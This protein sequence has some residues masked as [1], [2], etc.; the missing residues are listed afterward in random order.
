MINTISIDRENTDSDKQHFGINYDGYLSF[1]RLLLSF[2]PCQGFCTYYEMWSSDSAY[3]FSESALNDGNSTTCD[4]RLLQKVVHW[5]RFKQP[6]G[7]LIKYISNTLDSLK[8]INTFYL[9]PTILRSVYQYILS[10][11]F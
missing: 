2:L 3:T 11:I 9:L 4:R 8:R 7:M 1:A 10:P 6:C 5:F